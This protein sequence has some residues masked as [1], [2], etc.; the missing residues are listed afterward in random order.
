ML[1]VRVGVGADIQGTLR[2]PASGCGT[3]DINYFFFTRNDCQPE[4]SKLEG[5]HITD[6]ERLDLWW[7]FDEILLWL[8]ENLHHSIETGSLLWRI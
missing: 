5:K 1:V 2:W 4:Y 3:V 7:E 8:T 6:S